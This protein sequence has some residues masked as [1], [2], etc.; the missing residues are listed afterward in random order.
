MLKKNIIEEYEINIGTNFIKGIDRTKCYVSDESEDGFIPDSAINVVNNNCICNGSTLEGRNFAAS[1]LT[2]F[3]YKP[4]IILSESS[5]II[6]FPC[7]SHKSTKC[8]WINL[9]RVKR[10]I[11]KNK[12]TIIEFVDGKSNYFDVSNYVINNQYNKGLKLYYTMFESST[13]N[14]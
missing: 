10:I 8:L 3:K 7:D 11:Q 5:K 1:K 4:P 9:K 2:G 14:I 13:K 12:G 6:F